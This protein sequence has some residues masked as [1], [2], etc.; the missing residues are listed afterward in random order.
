M[1][2]NSGSPCMADEPETE[3]EKG[4]QVR[5]VASPQMWKYLGWLAKNTLLG[6]TEN[7]VARQ[8]LATKL[9][10]MKRKSYSP[11]DT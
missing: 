3:P 10:K 11:K 9:S 8:V 7:E 6:R 5:F 1:L 2:A 4:E